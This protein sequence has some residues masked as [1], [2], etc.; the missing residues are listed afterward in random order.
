[1]THRSR[2]ES[3]DRAAI[4]RFVADGE[5]ES[6]HL[7]FK[8]VRSSDL[9]HNDDKA[10]L[11]KALSGFANADG[12]ILVWGVDCRKDA[13]NVDRAQAERPVPDTE[14]FLSRLNELTPE[15]VSP[16]IAGV[17][18]KAIRDVGTQGFA[19][20]LVPTSESG[21]HMASDGR[22]YKRNGSSFRRME[23]FDLEDMFGRRRRP[24]LELVHEIRYEGQVSESGG[25]LRTQFEV[26]LGLRNVGRASGRAPFLALQAHDPVNLHPYGL[27]GNGHDGLQRL[28]PASEPGWFAFGGSAGTIIHPGIRHDVTKLRVAFYGTPPDVR[29][30]S[31]RYRTIAEEMMLKE[32]QI[33][34]EGSQ[35]TEILGSA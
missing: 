3:L 33:T 20:T 25:V 15:S 32:G 35:L 34:I 22:Y 17:E 18:H 11:T 27:D 30:V 19:A 6:L 24:S 29:S 13:N 1:M 26:R 7:D 10:S 21:P 8:T 31:F 4:A 5:Q 16:A 12:G 14:R 28:G 2:F 23:H 9:T